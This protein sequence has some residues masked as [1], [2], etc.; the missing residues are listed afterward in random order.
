MQRRQMANGAG[1]ENAA[2]VWQ[3][4]FC[5]RAGNQVERRRIERDNRDPGGSLDGHRLER[6]LDWTGFENQRPS[7]RAEGERR[8]NRRADDQ[9]EQGRPHPPGVRFTA[10]KPRQHQAQRRGERQHD[11]AALQRRSGWFVEHE[12]KR[13][14]VSPHQRGAC[15]RHRRAQPHQHADADPGGREHLVRKQLPQYE[16]DVANR[17]EVHHV[18]QPDRLDERDEMRGIERKRRIQ[19]QEQDDHVPGSHARGRYRVREH[20]QIA[21]FA[22]SILPR[23]RSTSLRK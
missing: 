4:A 23:C 16:E 9:D 22:R 6:R 19:I 17:G 15:H 1:V 5:A 3:P 14:E 13:D 8:R 2:E 10:A 21:H 11:R 12:R 7:R 18:E 20:P